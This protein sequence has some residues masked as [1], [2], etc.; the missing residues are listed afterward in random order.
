MS[1]V[2]KAFRLPK[3]CWPPRM[4]SPGIFALPPGADFP[5]HL[6]L[7]LTER[8]AD[9]PPEALARVTVYLNTARMRRRVTELF[10]AQGARF[11]PR[12]RLVTDLTLEPGLALPAAIPPLRLRLELAKL[13]AGLLD[14][15]P[16]LAP[17]AALYDL[18][19]SLAALIDEMQGEGVSPQAIAALDVSNHSKHWER[20]QT[21]LSIIAPLFTDTLNQESR[22]RLAV[23]RLADRWAVAPPQDPVLVAGS[24]ASR[25]TTALFM[26][27]V[28]RLP[29]G[30]LVLPGYDFETPA[31][32][33]SAMDD[34][35]T[36]EDHPQYRFRRLM[37][38]LAVSPADI[39]PWR[40]AKAPNPDRNRL[41]SLSLRPAP[42][43]DQWLI[44]GPKLPL[45][46]KT[47]QDITL[48]EAPTP[49][50]EA[51]A[52]ALI[53]REAA[54]TGTKAALIS[55]DR[56][57]T[58]QVTAA[59]DRWSILPDDSAGRPL[60]LSAPGRFLRH[61]AGLMG[62]KLT[63]DR[64]LTLLKHPLTA[65]SGDRGRHLLFTRHLE[66]KLR[67][68]GPSF[69]TGADLIAWAQ[70]R[71]DEGIQDWAS[72]LAQALDGLDS[73]ATRPL[74]D[75]VRQHRALAETLARGPVAVG[76]GGLW[77][78]PAG[79][80]ALALMD[81][82]AAEAPHGGSFSAP[83]YRDLFGALVNKGEV[84]ES[85]QAHPNIMIW[86]TLE[87]RVQGAE[88]VILGGLN[89]SVWPKL[90]EPDPWLNRSMRKNVALLLPERQIGLSAHDYQQA[91]AAPRV[92]L[93]RA[94]RNAEA[95]TVPSRWVNRLMNLMEGLPQ[96]DGPTALAQ[97][98]ARGAT[99]LAM[100]HALERPTATMQ[101]DPRLKPARRP[102]PRPPVAA[103]P[104][105]LSLTNIARLI[106]DPYAIYA[107]HVLKLYP[108]DPLH[109]APDP[110]DRGMVVH[111]VLERFVRTR[112]EAEQRA[113]ARR[114]LLDI[115][116]TV[117]AE[118]TPFPAARILW[119]SR[120]D[121]AADHFLTQ[122][123][124]HGGTPL[125]VETKGTVLLAPLPFTLYGTP[126][127]IDRLPDGR[128]QMI[129]YKTGSPP[130]EAQQRAYEKQLLLAAAMAERGGFADLGPSEVAKISYI[131]LGAGEKAVETDM[132]SDLLAQE[133]DRLITLISRYQTRATGYTAR[134]ALFLTSFAG[135][136]DHLSRF[137]EWQMSDRAEAETV[138]PEETE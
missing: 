13:I 41:I 89:D 8:L 96:L 17:R 64:L 77:D 44:E 137:G 88:L 95:E 138:G 74:S 16:E 82:L 9:Q 126:D 93:T 119:L 71:P 20:T 79:I 67:R 25:G 62:E 132:T 66:L 100:A 92:V 21:F 113:Q 129:D 99:W 108:L 23:A 40:D 28:A 121:R 136:Y 68:H 57:L 65:S 37:D 58:R 46:P 98:R 2:P 30:A 51:L 85:V 76:T 134:R 5:A 55:P 33:W 87:A 34:A 45:L 56:N 118:Q 18:A 116:A 80:A 36:A 135:D 39:Q 35:L 27:A 123:A 102:A 43:T 111:E 130:S 91:I 94:T 109:A 29:Q 6:A 72:F 50:A 127:R 3:P 4:F 103:R 54:E 60:A 97:M 59:L 75:H 69:P 131:G 115:A 47:T 78:K 133:W 110:R 32:V 15:Q 128:L 120:L 7:G 26:Q 117:L 105:R 63:A 83:A 107:R 52:I 24:T 124:R 49:R 61:V 86:G 73:I 101:A 48:I 1:A 81:N 104:D 22:Q 11:L 10:T 122:D 53:L 31:A 90:P 125:V 114:R 42:V 38:L 106:R 14:A 19:D 84:R 12:L 112:P 70:T